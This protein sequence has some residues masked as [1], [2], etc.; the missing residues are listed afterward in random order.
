MSFHGLIAWC[1]FVCTTAVHPASNLGHT[2]AVHPA[3]NLRHKAGAFELHQTLGHA[4]TAETHQAEGRTDHRESTSVA[5]NTPALGARRTAEA[6]ERH[7]KM[8]HAR[9]IRTAEMHQASAILINKE[10]DVLGGDDLQKVG[11]VKDHHREVKEDFERMMSTFLPGWASAY[12]YAISHSVVTL[13]FLLVAVLWFTIFFC[14]IYKTDHEELESSRWSKEN[15]EAPTTPPG[16]KHLQI[17]PDIVL[18]FHHPEHDYEDHLS[19]A[20]ADSFEQ[21]LRPSRDL[22]GKTRQKYL[23]RT[24]DLKKQA[25]AG[26][27]QQAPFLGQARIGFLKDVYEA[28]LEMGF[29]VKVFSSC[30]QDE[31]LLGIKLSKVEVIR[32]YL[33]DQHHLLRLSKELIPKLGI[34]QPADVSPPMLHYTHHTIKTLH[35]YGVIATPDEKYVYESHAHRSHKDANQSRI[36]SRRDRIRLISK[37]L[38]TYVDLDAA[39]RESFLVAWYPVHNAETFPKWGRAWS[40]LRLLLDTSFVQPVISIDTYFGSRVAFIFAWNGFYC[41]ALFALLPLA[42]VAEITALSLPYL[43]SHAGLNGGFDGTRMVLLGFS[44]V[45][46]VWSRLASNLWWREEA[47]FTQVWSGSSEQ[48]HSIIRPRFRGEY[49]P[50]VQNENDLEKQYPENLFALRKFATFLVTVTFCGLI[51]L[52]IVIW[53]DIFK[54]RLTI[55]SGMLVVIQLKLFEVIWNALT[56]VLTEF[57][58]HKYHSTYYDSYIWKNFAF[59]FVNNSSLFFFIAIKLENSAEGCPGGSCLSMLKKYLVFVQ[60]ALTGSNIA[61]LFAQSYWGKFLLW[62]EVYQYKKANNGEEPPERPRCEQEAKMV[63]FRKEDQINIMC[64]LMLSVSFIILFGGIAPIMI[65]F[66]LVFFAINLRVCAKTMVEYKQRPFPREQDG[67]GAWKDIMKLLIS[68][69]VLFNAYLMIVESHTLR[70]TPLVTKLSIFLI[71][72]IAMLLVW[73]VVDAI[74]PAT[75][76]AAKNLKLQNQC[77]LDKIHDMNHKAKKTEFEEIESIGSPRLRRLTTTKFQESPIGRDAWSEIK[78]VAKEA[79][80]ESTE[81]DEP[82][83]T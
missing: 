60:L 80:E 48:E 64:Q 44:V 20:S 8:H 6:E 23:Q 69:G 18:V 40:N 22:D 41:K 82:Y 2:K 46:I 47:Y 31:I 26:G 14:W 4:S 59:Q 53:Y 19:N 45:V 13:A 67:I 21:I 29:N 17:Q 73:Q 33:Y 37:A 39:V 24:L 83:S 77:V 61:F 50:M 25:D 1:I 11:Q 65:P 28:L 34:K 56:P 51:A 36:I 72:S 7:I 62:Y 78:P 38:L 10:P 35:E 32:S 79:I 42:L 71:Y 15:G 5:A 16:K 12:G 74:V 63:R 57:E 55:L 81:V 70:G 30:D 49:K 76:T 54:G 75:S 9:A 58:N 27:S 3:A 68:V 52:L 66:S 43:F